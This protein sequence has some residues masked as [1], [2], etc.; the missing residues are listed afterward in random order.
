MKNMRKLTLV[1]FAIFVSISWNINAQTYCTPSWTSAGNYQIGTQQVNIGS[2]SNTTT[3]PTTSAQYSNYTSMS[4]TAYPASTVNVSVQVGGSNTTWFCIFIDFNNDG[5]FNTNDEW[6]YSSGS[7]AS[8]GWSTGTIT[9]PSNAPAG[10]KRMRVISDYGSSSLNPP[11][12]CTNYYAGECEDYTI[13]ILSLSGFDCALTSVDSPGVFSVDSNK[14]SVTFSNLKADSIRWLDLG[15]SL[16]GG[17]PEQIFDYNKA[18]GTKFPV[19]GPGE[20]HMYTFDKSVFVPTKGSHSLKVWIGDVNDSFPDNDITNDTL[21]LNFCTGMEG[22]YTIGPIAGDYATFNEAVQALQ[23]CGVATPIVFQVE[24]GVYNERVVIPDNIVGISATNTITFD[25][26]DRTKVTLTY[27]GTSSS[28]RATVLFDGADYFTFRNMKIQNTGTSYSVAVMLMNQAD[29]NSIIDCD[30]TVGTNSSSYAQVIQST[31]SEASTGGNGDNANYTLV[32]NCTLSNGYYGAHFRGSGS[33]SP[34]MDNRIIDCIFNG[35]YYYGIYYYYQRGAQFI[36]N[37]IDIGYSTTS[38]YGIYQQYGSKSI[39]D[40]NNVMPGQY[41]IYTYYENYYYQGD[42]SLVINNLI[43][44]FKNPTYQVGYRGYYYNYNLRV[45]NNTIHVDGSYANSYT[46]AAMQFY[47]PYHLMCLN[48]IL[49]SDG[50]TMLLTVY[51]YPYGNGAVIDYNDYIYPSSTTN[52]MFFNYN[53][54]YLDLD[55]WKGAT[56]GMSM[57]HDENSWENE[58]PKFDATN[59]Y[60]LNPNYPPLV[61]K[62]FGYIAG[63]IDGDPRCI[64]RTAIG[65]DESEYSTGL[66]VSNFIAGDTICFNSPITFLNTADK[67]AKQGYWWFLNGVQKT[68]DFNFTHTFG[69]GTYYDTITLV[70]SNCAGSDTFTKVVLIDAPATPPMADFIAEMNEIE[71]GFPIQFFDISSNCPSSWKW[72]V[73]PATVTLGGLGTVPSHSYLAPTGSFSQN[74]VVLLEY[75]GVYKICLTVF[76]TI[77]GDSICKDKYIVVKPSQWICNYVLPSVSSSMR[78]ILFDDQGPVSD[79]GNGRNCDILLSPCASSID[80]SFTEFDVAG[81]DYFR[82]FEG[83]D[84]NGTPLWDVNNYGNNGINGEISD[85]GFQSKFTS[86][87]G[88]LFIEWETNTSGTAP[89]FVGSWEATAGQ[90]AKPNALFDGPDTVCLDAVAYFENLSTSNGGTN[91]WDYDQDGFYDDFNENGE[92]KFPFAGWY[93][94]KLVVEDCGGTSSYT[95]NVFVI[96]PP[97]APTPN[98]VADILRPVA[99]KDAVS[100]TD[101][102]QGCVNAWTWT[103]TPATFSVI[104]DYPNGQNP[105]IQFNDTG[106]YSVT[107]ESAFGSFTKSITKTDYIYV[108]QYCVPGVTTLGQDVGISYVELTDFANTPILVNA[109]AIGSESFTDYSATKSAYLARGASYSLTVKRNTNYNNIDRKA[110]IDW[111][112]NGEYEASELIDHEPNASTTSW[113]TQFAVPTTALKGTTRMRIATALGGETNDPCNTRLFGEVEE[114]RLIIRDDATP[115]VITITYMDTVYVEQCLTYVDSGATAE[116]NLDGN[117]TSSIVT[118]NNVDLQN[119]GEYWYKYEVSDANG[120]VAT[121]YRVIIV[122]KEMD[123]PVFTL[124]GNANEYVEVH[125][126]FVDPGY[127]VSDA[128]SG[129]DTVMMVSTVDIAELGTYMVDYTAYDNN[130]NSSMLSRT[131]VVGDTTEPVVT[132]NGSSPVMI[133][134]HNAYADM[135]VDAVDNYCAKSENAVFTT[136][137]VNTDILGTYTISY[138]VYDCN[139]NGPVMVSRD[140]IVADT[141]APAIY[142]GMYN[143]GDT[144]TMEVNNSI[145]DYLSKMGIIDNYYDFAELILLP[146]G[147]YFDNFPAPLGIANKLGYYSASLSV[148]DPSMNTSMISFTILVVDTEAPVITNP[149]TDY[150]EICRF[151]KVD[152]SEL[153][154]NVTDNFET[155]ITATTSGTYFSEYLN[156]MKEGFYSIRFSAI[157]GSG[158]KAQDY[159]KYVDV[160]YCETYSINDNDLAG[161]IALYPNPTSGQFNLEVELNSLEQLTINIVN[162]LGEVVLEVENNEVLNSSYKVDLSEFS[163]GVYYVSIKTANSVMVKQVVL[164]K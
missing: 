129:V 83:T 91:S 73:V 109:S 63:D 96:Q 137:A 143:E 106:Y 135:G 64:Y 148:T 41:G 153:V 36:N 86:S 11:S 140:V 76:N 42:S 43:H 152:A 27:A 162:V 138:E 100:F 78:G 159:T 40:G 45:L 126:A 70:T 151:A 71:T 67:N 89:G 84:N 130:N 122:N 21:F 46:Y 18:T 145:M 59:P 134:V 123:A 4:T 102:T 113:T 95:K 93:S 19:L 99:G 17:T 75:P 55:A 141:T 29:N 31:S 48:N 132:L 114:Y 103:I 118:T 22:T 110:W 101:L 53:V 65:A 120:N 50:G 133:E 47:Y 161:N 105:I 49:I 139:G 80:F 69:A 61:G 97:V 44:D 79:Y 26:L 111:N 37:T 147:T 77:G 136:G 51:Y 125:N 121:A 24:P 12:P 82:I 20:N 116:D 58:D 85:P 158:N 3:C 108:I 112:V 1:L 90:F 155:G 131:V 5:T 9:I 57:P 81:G 107:L 74:P 62:T 150:I 98:F 25:G 117:V 34:N 16:N 149:G 66:P 52:N 164:A 128:C 56:Q 38:A 15:Y 157:D 94:V 87:T 39:I 92:Y 154:V 13:K 2:I 8:S 33:T 72:S 88:S 30:M 142:S 23:T 144:I 68:T 119:H 104:A 28:N 54:Y 115:P 163:N 6:V 7:T 124:K 127:D 14:L 10:N 156:H 146:A 60:H 35:Q 160:S 32:Q